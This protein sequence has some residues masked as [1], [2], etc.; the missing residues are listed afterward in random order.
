MPQYRRAFR[1]GGT[2][3]LTIVTESR[4]PILTTPAARTTLHAAIDT[5]RATRPFT[6]D[7]IVL[8]PDHWHL[9]LTLPAGDADYPTRIAAIKSRF[10]RDY[11]AHGGHEQPRSTSRLKSRRRG[12]WQRHF[13]EHDIRD[14]TDYERHFDYI[15]YNPVRHQ[16]A[17]CPHA[18]PYSSYAQAVSHNLY[19]CDWQ[20]RCNHRTPIPPNFDTLPI[21]HM[22]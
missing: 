21:H 3:F 19:P 18:W 12:V 13:W 16:Y 11:L 20:C 1:P 17:G 4:A 8:L 22:E 2:F 14:H 5:C 9:M 6:I 15:L 10:T 7:A